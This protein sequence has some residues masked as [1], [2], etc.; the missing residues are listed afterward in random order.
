[1]KSLEYLRVLNEVNIEETPYES[2]VNKTMCL[3]VKNK[4][5]LQTN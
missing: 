4:S 5:A 2:L 3:I 1:M